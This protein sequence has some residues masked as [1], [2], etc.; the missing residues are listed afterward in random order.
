MT[1]ILAE[2]MYSHL[3]KRMYYHLNKKNAVKRIVEQKSNCSLI[4]RCKETVG[5]D[6]L[7]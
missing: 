5:G 1:R 3:E 2:K 6:T 4:K 7:I